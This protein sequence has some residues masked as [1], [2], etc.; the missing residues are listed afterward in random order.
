MHT[1]LAHPIARNVSI[2]I[3]VAIL[4]LGAPFGS[5][6]R[7]A[8]SELAVRLRSR[9]ETAPGSGRFHAVHSDEAWNAAETAIIVCDMWDL[10]HCLNATR[11]GEEL[12]DRMNQ[13]LARF[14]NA[15]A[16]V[17]H[18]PSGCVAFYKDHP[19]RARM[20]GVRPAESFPEE[21]GQWCHK[22]PD[23]ERG[24]Y[25]IDQ[26]DGGEDDDPA[27]HQAWADQLAAL[28][29]DPR[30]PWIR[31]TELLD[32]D[33]HRDY[34]S[35]DGKEIWSLL[36]QRAIRNV[37]LVGV[38]TN[39]CVLGRPFGLRNMSRYGKRVVLM[40]DMTDTMYNPRS[41]PRVSHFAG[42]DLI[43]EHIEKWVCPTITSDQVLG[44]APFRFSNDRRPRVVIASSEDEYKTEIWLPRFAAEHLGRQF[45]VACV[46]GDGE[47][48]NTMP[49][50]V[51]ALADA[52]LLLVSVRRRAL[53]TSSLESVRRFVKRGKAVVG[54][55]TANHAFSPRG[56][57]PPDGRL[58]WE[59]WDHDVIGGNYTGHHG[60][61][62]VVSVTV[63]APAADHPILRGIDVATLS[64]R[65]SLYRVS[66][67]RP[68]TTALLVGTIEGQPAEPVAWTH[69][70]PWGGRVFYTSL[71]HESDF[72]Q[73]AFREL[74]VHAIQWASQTAIEPEPA[75]AAW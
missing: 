8:D 27:E 69:V 52:D 59:S 21:I 54:I 72:A 42:T 18:A 65:G 3:L 43:I 6:G 70:N 17:I 4:A 47:D 41:A 67:L 9:T 74:L 32:I 34:I 19:A 25:P 68:G 12:A 33:E 73:P 53:P 46:F 26:S 23:E 29:R 38:H 61:G 63:H 37:V 39:M 24:A 1:I 51:E 55:R 22:I 30:A 15:G 14:R 36:E 31:Q 11:R 57:T 40:R 45:H 50:L 13:V 16:A 56:Q 28:G 62:P 20:L 48:A 66:P 5:P 35:D 60:N 64:S 2:A 58:A 75:S 10:H 44:G 7:G 49:G 71:G